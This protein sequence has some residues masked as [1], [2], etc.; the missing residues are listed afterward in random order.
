MLLLEA[1]SLHV[2]G[3]QALSGATCRERGREVLLFGLPTAGY[4]TTV[5]AVL[6]PQL[7]P[8]PAWT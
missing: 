6:S 2:A 1:V 8:D 4:L 5:V 7:P 3:V